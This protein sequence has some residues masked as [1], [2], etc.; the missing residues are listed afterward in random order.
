MQLWA[1]LVDD[2]SYTFDNVLPYYK[3]TVHFT[4][5]NHSPIK[6]ARFANSTP[7]YSQTAFSEDGK[8]LQVS[9]PNYAMSFSSWMGH[10]MRSIGINATED[11]NSGRL[12]G[13]QYCSSTIEPSE[14]K[15]S[16]S[17]ASFLGPGAVY[18]P[19]LT[20]YK[21]TLA[22]RIL[23]NAH[24]RAIGVEVQSAALVYSLKAT[25][26]VILSAGAF[27]SP[28][29]LMVSGIGPAPTLERHGVEVISN[30]P[31]VGQ[32]MQDHVFF[33]P[34]YRVALETFT[35]LPADFGFL[36]GE[37]FQYIFTHTGMLTNPITD[38][39]AFEKLPKSERSTFS[40]N[41]EKELSQFP[42]D[43]PE[44]EVSIL[45]YLLMNLLIELPVYF[46]RC[47]CRQL[48]RTFPTTTQR[49]PP[50]CRHCSQPRCPYISWK[51]HNQFQTYQRP[52][53]H[54]PQLAG[55]GDRP[56]GSNRCI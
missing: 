6:K 41:T 38:F 4:P 23:F 17:E 27:Q 5:P 35:K 2:Q 9:Y 55:Y 12:L 53:H 14:Q 48:L 33:G 36:I 44:V 1:D 45:G 50:V 42:D 26:E 37:L 51:C 16:T 28:Q 39:L 24:K 30:L 20:I 18:L 7:E 54:K 49:W 11:F 21:N 25:R 22:R 52:A 31:G 15:R 40:L 8:P 47:I 13:A 19:T 3:R 46:S 34:T 29:L 10:G 32:N 43:W 56:A